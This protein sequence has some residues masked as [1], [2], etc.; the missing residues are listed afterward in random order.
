[1]G[2]AAPWP[3]TIP[4]ESKSPSG[5]LG[6]RALQPSGVD[7]T[8]P[9]PFARAM[10]DLTL[11]LSTLLIMPCQ[12]PFNLHIT[13]FETT[14]LFLCQSWIPYHSILYSELWSSAIVM[15]LRSGRARIL[16]STTSRLQNSS[17][18][19][20]LR[21]LGP[22]ISPYSLSV[23]RLHNCASRNRSSAWVASCRT[24]PN[25]RSDLHL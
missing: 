5:S 16:P 20:R 6:V 21:W 9:S 8:Q 14:S 17:P 18:Q 15:R 11:M 22:T 13:A 23:Y 10:N 25:T 7:D 4:V 19:K 12:L 2:R 1:M 24:F 3:S